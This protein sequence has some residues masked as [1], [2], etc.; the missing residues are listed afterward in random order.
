MPK[1]FF[2][3]FGKL[4]LKLIGQSKYPQRRHTC[5]REQGK[6]KYYHVIRMMRAVMSMTCYAWDRH[7]DQGNMSKAS[8]SKDMSKDQCTQKA[9][10]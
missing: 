8:V 4:V 10:R 1:W 6:G 5:A 3:T 2:N 7:M 9:D